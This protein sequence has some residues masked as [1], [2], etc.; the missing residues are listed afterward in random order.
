M[1]SLKN[2]N[3]LAWKWVRVLPLNNMEASR[4]VNGY[5]PFI[6]RANYVCLT[7]LLLFAA[8]ACLPF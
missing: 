7:M 1:L 5:F 8:N 2:W 4:C 6:S 3:L